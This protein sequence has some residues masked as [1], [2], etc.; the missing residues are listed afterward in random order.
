MLGVPVKEA[1][2]KASGK[3]T[4][5]K[6]RLVAPKV[7]VFCG[8]P[9]T[10]RD[11]VPPKAFFLPPR[12]ENLVTVPACASCN[13]G[14]SESDDRF[15]NFVS[16]RVGVGN[17]KRL[18]LWKSKVLPGIRRNRKE[19]R[20][21]VRSMRDVEVYT[22]GGIYLGMA[23]QCAFEAEPHDSGIRRTVRGLYW[24]QFKEALPPEI[25][26]EVLVLGQ[27]WKAALGPL[28]PMMQLCDIGGPETFQYAFGRVADAPTASLWVFNFF[29]GHIVAAMTGLI[30]E[31]SD[32]RLLPVPG[33]R[34]RPSRLIFRDSLAR[35]RRE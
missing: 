22:P 4:S 18:D 11:H 25:P 21:L 7:C 26:I 34:S 35:T 8:R 29:A 10:T 13:N 6:R 17:S 32:H 9:A 19:F 1:K 12:P 5:T 23:T 15:R 14:A 27:N 20:R 33:E 16:L 28:L 2:T 24:Y 30:A 31:G 3:V